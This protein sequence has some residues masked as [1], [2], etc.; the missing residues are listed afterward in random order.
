MTT[1]QEQTDIDKRAVEAVKA[2]V[3]AKG[4]ES[5]TLEDQ[6]SNVGVKDQKRV[7]GSMALMQ[8]KM[9]SALYSEVKTS[10]NKGLSK[11]IKALNIFLH[12]EINFS[13]GQFERMSGGGTVSVATKGR[14]S[15]YSISTTLCLSYP[16][17]ARCSSMISLS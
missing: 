3:L 4:T 12:A 13:F 15:K 5:L 14:E 10:V 2:L 8:E 17:S 7:S 11:N 1:Q 9:N 16:L 6:I